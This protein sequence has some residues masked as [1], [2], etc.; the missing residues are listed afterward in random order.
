MGS[1]LKRL[2][3]SP[4]IASKEWVYRQYD[5]IVRTNTVLVP[6]SDAAVI[7]IKGSRKGLALT[8]DGNG[9]YCYLDPYIG[10]VLAVSEAAR[11]LACVG[12]KT[13]GIERLPQLRKSGTT[14]CDVAIHTDYPGNA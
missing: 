3:A 1:A 11:N 5:Y 14:R 12:A 9:R 6:G 13:T 4:N 10:G 2:L 7:R 8:V